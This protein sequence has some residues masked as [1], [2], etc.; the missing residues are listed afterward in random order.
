MHV[1]VSELV[2]C[3]VKMKGEGAL[4]GIDPLVKRTPVTHTHTHIHTFIHTCI[5][6]HTHTHEYADTLSHPHRH[7]YQTQNTHTHVCINQCRGCCWK[8]GAAYIHY[9]VT[10]SLS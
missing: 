10:S 8:Q 3:C 1:S 7:A 9:Y 6:T 5:H 2:L 4:G